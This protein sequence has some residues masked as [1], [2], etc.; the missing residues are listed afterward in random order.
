VISVLQFVI[1]VKR[2]F[3]K[4]WKAWDLWKN[5]LEGTEMGGKDKGVV[6]NNG[7]AL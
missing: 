4:S 2:N 1:A 7:F 6:K 5:G 3:L